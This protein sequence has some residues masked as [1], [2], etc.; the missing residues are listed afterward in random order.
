[1]TLEQI[2][3]AAIAEQLITCNDLDELLDDLHAFAA[4]PTT[5]MALPRIVQSWGYRSQSPA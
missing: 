4:D 5:L 1:M 3:D 2:G